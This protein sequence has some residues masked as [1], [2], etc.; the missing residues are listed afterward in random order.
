MELQFIMFSFY[1]SFVFLTSFF[2]IK[3]TKMLHYLGKFSAIYSPNKKSKAQNNNK[4]A[5]KS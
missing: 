1:F 2:K 3:N 5:H 4:K